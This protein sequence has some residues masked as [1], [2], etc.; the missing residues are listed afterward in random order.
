MVRVA[1]SG[2]LKPVRTDLAPAS[3]IQS[4]KP[5]KDLNRFTAAR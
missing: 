2:H 5:F 3:V 1:I 4:P